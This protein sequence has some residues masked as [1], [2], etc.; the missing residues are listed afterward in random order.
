MYGA[1]H[2]LVVTM[3][4]NTASCRPDRIKR[5][6]NHRSCIIIIFTLFLIDIKLLCLEYV[7]QVNW[8]RLLFY[9]HVTC[10]MVQRFFAKM[11]VQAIQ[12]NLRFGVNRWLALRFS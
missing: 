8:I 9:S 4:E 1:I 11:R 3:I 6:S 2:I 10:R 5:L 12:V 7:F